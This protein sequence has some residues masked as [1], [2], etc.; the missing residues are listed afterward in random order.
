[1]SATVTAK[2]QVTIPKPVRDFLGLVPGTRL[3]FEWAADIPWFSRGRTK[4]GR[5]GASARCAAMP[6]KD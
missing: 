1:M 4:Y 6:E 5:Q 3:E 2:G